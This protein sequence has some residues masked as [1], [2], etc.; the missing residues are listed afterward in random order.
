LFFHQ[1][2]KPDLEAFLFSYS[3]KL[4]EQH[5]D[6]SKTRK[7]FPSE[8]NLLCFRLRSPP[9]GGTMPAQPSKGFLNI[10]LLFLAALFISDKKEDASPRCF[11]YLLK[12]I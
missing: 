9:E 11:N 4:L 8:E 3:N 1:L 12:N 7:L 5:L 2:F 10:Q 6:V